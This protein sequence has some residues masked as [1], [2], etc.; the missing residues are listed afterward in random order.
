[1]TDFMSSR[2]PPPAPP[3]HALT[4]AEDS[5]IDYASETDTALNTPTSWTTPDHSISTPHL[6]NHRWS[7]SSSWSSTFSRPSSIQ[8]NNKRSSEFFMPRRSISPKKIKS[9]MHHRTSLP[10][11]SITTPISSST[12][13][14]TN[15]GKLFSKLAAFAHHSNNNHSTSDVIQ[16]EQDSYFINNINVQYQQQKRED[17]QQNQST[18]PRS[19]HYNK[20]KRQQQNRIH[21]HESIRVQRLLGMVYQ[22]QLS[23]SKDPSVTENNNEAMSA[24]CTQMQMYLESWAD[25]KVD[26]RHVVRQV[27]SSILSNHRSFPVRSKQQR[28]RIVGDHF[29]NYQQKKQNQVSNIPIFN[30]QD[31]GDEL[32]TR[33]QQKLDSARKPLITRINELETALTACKYDKNQVEQK[34]EIVE[35]KLTTMQATASTTAEHNNDNIEKV[36][37]EKS[38]SDRLSVVSSEDDQQ[39]NKDTKSPIDDER[40]KVYQEASIMLTQAQ[41]TI[42]ELE[43]KLQSANNLL[44]EKQRELEH[45][46]IVPKCNCKQTILAERN[47]KIQDL[48]ATL[49]QLLDERTHWEQQAAAKYYH[50]KETFKVQVSRQVRELAGTIAEQ[51]SQMDVLE[52]RRQQDALTINR[53]ESLKR[54]AEQKCQKRLNEWETEEKGLRMTI[55]TLEAKVVKLEQDTIVLYGKNLKLAHQ[56]GQW[57]P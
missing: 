24:F 10:P 56:L 7:L 40:E 4:F 23:S 13:T 32:E 18:L 21:R 28:K 11:N 31:N 16:E 35:A 46:K 25:L 3:P 29:H 39:N 50:E 36:Y 30:A 2:G 1:M 19:R 54:A 38:T 34:L 14:P 26:K 27:N 8:N 12:S 48:E 57:A 45:A 52:K 15:S 33:I 20:Q 17:K 41:K 22:F 37:D 51:E 43:L 44:F 49:Q 47:I 53:V 6:N 42:T 5:A 55:A 9:S